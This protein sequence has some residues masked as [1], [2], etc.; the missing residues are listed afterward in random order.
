MRNALLVLLLQLGHFIGG[1]LVVSIFGEL[2]LSDEEKFGVLDEVFGLDGAPAQTFELLDNPTDFSIFDQQ[3]KT[4]GHGGAVSLN[5]LFGVFGRTWDRSVRRRRSLRVPDRDDEASLLLQTKVLL[6]LAWLRG[7]REHVYEVGLAF[8]VGLD[9]GIDALAD[10]L[11]WE[12][13]P[14]SREP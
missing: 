4:R 13:R 1:A 5:S 2:V 12:I 6:E 3:K 14:L 11:S 10:R 9:D 8:V 7:G